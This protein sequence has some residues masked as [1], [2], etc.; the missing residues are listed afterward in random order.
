MQVS[1][2]ILLWT[3][4]WTGYVYSYLSYTLTCIMSTNYR[5]EVCLT[6]LR[7]LVTKWQL[8]VELFECLSF[9]AS[10]NIEVRSLLRHEYLNWRSPF[11]PGAPVTQNG[12][13]VDL[14]SI[15]SIR[16]QVSNKK[17]RSAWNLK[18]FTNKLGC[19]R[20]DCTQKHNQTVSTRKNS[21]AKLEWLD[22]QTA[23]FV[24]YFDT[25]RAFFGVTKITLGGSSTDQ[26]AQKAN[27][28][29]KMSKI[30]R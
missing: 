30:S 19:A 23:C 21:L 9:I 22:K 3:L 8:C 20:F 10:T 26:T 7:Y 2:I 6:M 27:K 1:V 24:S 18:I 5:S 12:C 14:S 11:P 25:L 29:S 17:I 13:G 28:N 4:H 15:Y 16:G